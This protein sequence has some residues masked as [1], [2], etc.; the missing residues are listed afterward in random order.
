LKQAASTAG[1]SSTSV[2]NYSDAVNKGQAYGA[3]YTES[4]AVGAAIAA[5]PGYQ[6][7]QSNEQNDKD[8][9]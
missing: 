6:R 4:G 1:F 7:P 8:E 2:L 5:N 9:L 3:E